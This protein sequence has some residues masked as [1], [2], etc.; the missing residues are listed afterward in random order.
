MYDEPFPL[1]Y[2]ALGVVIALTM[3]FWS[4]ICKFIKRR[5]SR[6]RIRAEVDV[7]FVKHC[8]QMQKV[9]ARELEQLDV[10]LR[11]RYREDLEWIELCKTIDPAEAE[12]EDK[13]LKRVFKGPRQALEAHQANDIKGLDDWKV[14]QIAMRLASL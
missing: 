3:L 2:K 4:Q 14:K 6:K 5:T 7:D 9:H 1:W 13:R 10:K 8:E 11:W 12:R